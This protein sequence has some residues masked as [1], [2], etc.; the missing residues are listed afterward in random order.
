[1]SEFSNDNDSPKIGRPKMTNRQREKMVQYRRYQ[2]ESLLSKGASQAD[3]A[4]VFRLTPATISRECKAIEASARAR[5]AKHIEEKIPFIYLSN[6]DGIDAVIKQAWFII[7]N[8]KSGNQYL[9][10]HAMSILIQCYRARQD[11]SS[12]SAVVNESLRL[13]EQTK[14]KLEE[15]EKGRLPEHKIDLSTLD[16]VPDMQDNEDEDET[17][18]AITT[19]TNDSQVLLSPSDNE[20]NTQAAQEDTNDDNVDTDRQDWYLKNSYAEDKDSLSTNND[21]LKDN[22]LTPLPI[23]EDTIAQSAEPRAQRPEPQA[24]PTTTE[25]ADDD[26]DAQPAEDNQQQEHEDSLG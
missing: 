16:E 9:K 18:D 4:T 7:Q 15:L 1:V 12:D 11:L 6:M 25:P 22:I 21:T 5:L 24:Q 14:H 19:T 23:S 3:C 13:M 10:I 2:I 8:P 20:G 17:E 26:D